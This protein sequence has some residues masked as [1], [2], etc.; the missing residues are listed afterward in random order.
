M[1]GFGFWYGGRSHNGYRRE[2]NSYD[3][4]R[5]INRPSLDDTAV[6]E[7]TEIEFK[8]EFTNIEVLDD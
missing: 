5:Y 6:E 8:Q 1:S 3:W 2:Y 4:Y 7:K